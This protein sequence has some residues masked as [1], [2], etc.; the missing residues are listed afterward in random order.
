[1]F[2]FTGTSCHNQGENRF[3]GWFWEGGLC[4][5]RDGKG[6]GGEVERNQKAAIEVIEMSS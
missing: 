6:E 2:F 5:L 1:M 3:K 4:N